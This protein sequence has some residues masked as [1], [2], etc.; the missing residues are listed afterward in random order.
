MCIPVLIIALFTIAKT[1]KQ[2]KCALTEAWMKMYVYLPG[3]GDPIIMRI[4]YIYPVEYPSA[5][6]K[7]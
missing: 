1:Q 7:P 5:I 3:R 6:K 4:W 2:P